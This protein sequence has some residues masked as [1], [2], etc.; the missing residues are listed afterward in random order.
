[1]KK[2]LIATLVGGAILFIWQFLS[3]AAIPVHQE[4]Y[5]YTPNQDKILELLSQNITEEGTYW[6]PMAPPGSSAEQQ[7]AV[8]ESGEGKPWASISYHKSLSTNMGMNMFRG[9]VVDL[10]AIFLLVWLL[11]KIETLTLS[12]AVQACLVVGFISYLTIP[13]L[14]SIWFEKNSLA[15]LLDAI[16]SWGAVGLW[17]GWW[18]PRRQ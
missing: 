15:H 16:V 12:T 9:F 14:N 2:Q 11:M 4:E 17:L 8:M 13:Y 7:Q 10:V 5:G 6:L 1:M 3:W 18:L